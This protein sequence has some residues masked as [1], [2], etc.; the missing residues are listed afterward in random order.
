ML[1]NDLA[2]SDDFHPNSDLVNDDCP[3][4]VSQDSEGTLY[5]YQE[6]DSNQIDIFQSSQS[7][8]GDDQFSAPNS[9][10]SN[11]QEHFQGHFNYQNGSLLRFDINIST[12]GS[13]HMQ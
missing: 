9:P 7:E 3:S 11:H 5:M 8:N 13:C 10:H 1:D 6:D 4:T 2:I 12:N